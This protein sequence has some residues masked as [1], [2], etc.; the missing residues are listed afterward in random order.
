[1]LCST[2]EL[3]TD[4][5]PIQSCLGLKV[6]RQVRFKAESKLIP[7]IFLAVCCI[8][9]LPVRLSSQPAGILFSAE[10]SKAH[11]ASAEQDPNKPASELN[12]HLLGYALIA[13]GMLVV[14]AQSSKRLWPLQHVWPFLF[15]VAGLF[16]AA[17]SDKE[18]WPRG[19]LSWT[20]LIHHD[21]E[22]RQHKIYA[23]LLLVM[24][25][26]ECLRVNAKLNRFWRA[27]S[28]PVLAVLGIVLLLFHD[29]TGASG[30]SS[31]EARKYVV[32][33]LADRTTE[34]PVSESPSDL[35]PHDH[36]M[37]PA[38]APPEAYQA[39]LEPAGHEGIDRHNGNGQPHRM[40][41]AMVKVEREHLWFALVG[42]LVVLFK[43]TL[44]STLWRRSF[45]PLLWPSCVAALGILL[46]LYTE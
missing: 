30:G 4:T 27:W 23:V 29:H 8:A 34:A 35:L 17:W 20:W 26:I 24:G 40:T 1:L 12:H 36:R 31:R 19:N 7:V 11:L 33:W 25:I 2:L 16:L 21:A 38:S 39:Q 13:I 14:G 28:F 43:V 45:V 37:M 18:M 22:A 6:K 41:A 46:V 10:T 44:D 15:V 9:T 5:R 42:V 3:K 32:Y